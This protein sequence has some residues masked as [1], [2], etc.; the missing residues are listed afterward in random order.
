MRPVRMIL[1]VEPDEGCG[2]ALACLVRRGGDRLRLVRTARAAVSAVRRD[3]Y[4]FALVDLSVKGGGVDLARRLARRVPRVY[5]SVGARLLTDELVEAALGFPVVRKRDL[6]DLFTRTRR[7][8]RRAGIKVP[9][10]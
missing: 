6:P 2:R 10:S 4:D 5:L 7:S 3:E 8:T 9:I 1:L